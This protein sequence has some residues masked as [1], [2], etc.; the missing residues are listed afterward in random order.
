MLDFFFLRLFFIVCLGFDRDKVG[1]LSF[2]GIYILIRVILF[3]YLINYLGKSLRCWINVIRF[4]LL[5]NLYFSR[6]ILIKKKRYKIGYIILYFKRCKVLRKKKNENRVRIIGNVYMWGGCVCVY[7][8]MG[9]NL[10]L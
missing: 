8:V 10:K 4:L 1:G 2:L 3:I 6:G 5:W 7:E 9:Y